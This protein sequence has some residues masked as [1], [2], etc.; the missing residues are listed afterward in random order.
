[1]GYDLHIT[2]KNNW[3]DDDDSRN[4]LLQEWIQLVSNDSEMRLDN[5]AEATLP[6]SETLRLESEGLSVWTK[7]SGDGVNGNHAW[8]RYHKGTI[9]VKN[10]D[11]EIIQKM[12]EIAAK[13]HAKVQ[14][15]E[16]ELYKPATDAAIKT[17]L[18]DD[19]KTTVVDKKPWW[20][21]W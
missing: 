14:G 6:D 10:P 12:I 20:K 15:D 7:Y 21:F 8:F 2:R 3:F 17:T 13:L 9:V 19:S 11:E 5:F 1:M 16:G 4:I 18:V